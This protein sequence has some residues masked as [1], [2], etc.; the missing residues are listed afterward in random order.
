MPIDLEDEAGDVCSYAELR[1]RLVHD[2]VD[3]A[4]VFELY[5]R[6]FYLFVFGV[7]PACVAQ[8]RGP[9]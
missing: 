1:L 4:V 7:R 2:L 8:T 9:R 3:Q 5:I 6:L